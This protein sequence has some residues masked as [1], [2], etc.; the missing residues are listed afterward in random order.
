[1]LLQKLNDLIIELIICLKRSFTGSQL[2]CL[3]SFCSLCALLFNFR[4]NRMHL[5]YSICN[6]DFNILFKLGYQAEQA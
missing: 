6:I 3:N 5:F 1:M 2:I 4:Q